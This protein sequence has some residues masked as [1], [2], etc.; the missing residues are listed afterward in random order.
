M[1]IIKEDMISFYFCLGGGGGGGRGGLG[2]G[3]GGGEGGYIQNIGIP[4]SSVLFHSL[5]VKTP[6][7]NLLNNW[8][9]LTR[10]MALS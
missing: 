4:D 7:L 3:G 8:A 2:G 9:V 6:I 10:N 1:T 5:F